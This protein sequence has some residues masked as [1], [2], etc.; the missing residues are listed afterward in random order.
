LPIILAVGLALVAAGLVF[1]YTRG[2]EQRAI[3]DQQPTTVLVSTGTIPRG[4]SLGE[5]VSGGLAEQS[6]VPASM[7]PT[8]AITAVTPENQDLLSLSDINAGQ[9]LLSTN[10]IAELPDV[11]PVAIPDGLIA[12]SVSLDDVQKVGNFLRPGAEVVVFD[13]YSNIPAGTD[14]ALATA[15]L[16]TRV[17]VDRAIVLGIGDTASTQQTSSDGTT[18]APPASTLITIGVDQAEAEKVIQASQTGSLFFGL[19]GDG[20]EIVKSNGTTAGNL[21]N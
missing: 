21:F 2:A 3:Q 10:F 17:L 15:D 12:I 13:S 18:T 16:T 19:L 1:F 14:A 9:I 8:G 11:S 6:Q 20:T 4:M 7:T 5:A